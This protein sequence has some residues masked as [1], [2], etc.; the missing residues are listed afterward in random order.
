MRYRY[1]LV[2][3]APFLY[4]CGGAQESETPAASPTS[5]ACGASTASEAASRAEKASLLRTEQFLVKLRQRGE[6]GFAATAQNLARQL[7]ASSTQKVAENLLRVTLPAPASALEE[8]ELL[9]PALYEYVE[10]D[11]RVQATLASNDPNL[12]RQWAHATVH[13]AEAWDI[14]RGSSNV[15]VAVLDSG[16]D[17]THTDLSDNIW[18]NPAEL[19]NG[20]DDDGDGYV[21]DIHGWNF[22]SN[23]NNPTADDSHY[24][25]TH[26]SGTVGAV[27]NNAVGISGHAQE[28][29][30]MPLKFLDSSGSGSVSDA[31]RGIDY[32]IAHGAKIISNSWGSYYRSQSLSDAISRAERAGVLFVAAAGNSSASNDKSP[33]YPA[34][35]PQSNVISVASSTSADRLSSFSNYGMF[36]VHL[37]APGSLI[38]STANGNGYQTLSGTS[39]ATPLISGVLATMIAARPDLSF[40][41]IKGALLSTVDVIPTMTDRLI[42]NGRVNAERALTTVVSVPG[43][44]QAPEAPVHACP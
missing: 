22:V 37:A 35:Y 15:I 19:S 23:N 40:T 20:L 41:Q 10:P 27:G 5:N 36:H 21:D 24:H 32:A 26:V 9:D 18:R 33:F 12:G 3:L 25:G 11:F 1:A 13:S 42:W 7:G 8:R 31:V 28:V 44:W 39:M 6:R 30:I 14:S 4:A 2:L 17:L 16:T 43:D 34:N 38:Y 29:K